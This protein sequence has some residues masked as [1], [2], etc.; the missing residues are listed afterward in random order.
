LPIVLLAGGL[1]ATAAAPASASTTRP[2]HTA[3]GGFVTSA[4][5]GFAIVFADGSIRPVI[6]G[7]AFAL[8]LPSRVNAAAARPGGGYWEVAADGNVL[9]YGTA[10]A[11]GGT[12]GFPLNQPI[13]AIVPT[14]RG[15]GYWLAARDGGIF[16]FGDARFFGSVGARKLNQPIVGMETNPAGTGYLLVARDGGVF[17][18]GKIKFAGSLP[19][20][21]IH[22]TDVIGIAPTPTGNGYWIAR[23]DGHVHPFGDAEQLGGIN[24]S[25]CNRFTAIIANPKAQGYRLVADSGRTFAFGDAPGGDRPTGPPR[26]CGHATARIELSSSAVTAG[27]TV[28]GYFVVDNQT[29]APLHL[30]DGGR[31]QAKWAVT[32]SSPTIPNSPVFTSECRRG[33]LTFP[34]GA[35]QLRFTLRANYMTSTDPC[36]CLPPLPAGTYSARFFGLGGTFPPVAPV[37]VTVVTP[38]S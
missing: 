4:P 36:A 6:G 38:A 22:V 11:L 25:A 35:S 12:G 31:C 19:G 17:A 30:R 10:R 32:L 15:N 3:V 9:N 29:R 27:T 7:D 33:A 18:F 8:H 16:T 34:V 20:R 37:P 2:P 13:F 14:K 1:L 21:H 23:S 5:D 28:T 26:Q 24:P